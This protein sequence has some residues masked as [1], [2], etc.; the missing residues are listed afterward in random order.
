M[1]GGFDSVN[2][3]TKIIDEFKNDE[4]KFVHFEYF[5]CIA[6]HL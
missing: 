3:G 6:Q 1:L 4:I 5:I 2:Y